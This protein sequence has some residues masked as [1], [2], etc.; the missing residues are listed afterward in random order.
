MSLLSNVK[1]GIQLWSLNRY[2]PDNFPKVLQTVAEQGY[3]GVEF[4]GFHGLTA[5]ELK[6][7]MNDLGLAMAGSHTGVDLL[8]T[9]FE[10]TTE[11]NLQLGNTR[12]IIP[13]V[14]EEVRSSLAGWR[15]FADEILGYAE[16]LKA[17]GLTIGYHNHDFEF[18]ETEG[19]IPFYEFFNTLPAGVQMQL[20]MGWCFRAGHDAR[21][22]FKKYPGRSATV[23]V[24]AFCKANDTA[25]VGEDDINWKEVLPVAVETGKAEWFIV[26]HERHG[27]NKPEDSTQICLN[28]LKSLQ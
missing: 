26:E 12:L 15:K 27:D 20:D 28:Y 1:I 25:R 14:G 13:A 7:R 18:V 21:D 17:L 6:M 5:T 24:K 19:K 4:A 3:D 23:H 2:E 16:R 11:Y 10:A 9:Q 8:R 22:I